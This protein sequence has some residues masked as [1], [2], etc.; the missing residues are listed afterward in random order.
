[1]TVPRSEVP[2]SQLDSCSYR[3]DWRKK[4]MVWRTIAFSVWINLKFPIEQ[5]RQDL[6]TCCYGSCHSPQRWF[7]SRLARSVNSMHKW[8]LYETPDQRRGYLWM[9]NLQNW[10]ATSPLDYPH[11]TSQGKREPR[12]SQNPTIDHNKFICQRNKTQHNSYI[13]AR[14]KTLLTRNSQSRNVTDPGLLAHTP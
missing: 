12:L 6:P 13:V 11:R 1:M 10:L 3:P 5:K 9:Y 2:R 4:S 14:R 8:G 7:A